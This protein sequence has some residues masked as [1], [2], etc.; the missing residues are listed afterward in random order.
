MY[1]CECF[2]SSGSIKMDRL[3]KDTTSQ[4]MPLAITSEV[5]PEERTEFIELKASLTTFV[6]ELPKMKGQRKDNMM[7]CIQSVI[8]NYIDIAF[9]S[10]VPEAI[11]SQHIHILCHEEMLVPIDLTSWAAQQ[12]DTVYKMPN[13]SQVVGLCPDMPSLPCPPK[14]HP[15][16]FS[17]EILYHTIICCSAFTKCERTTCRQY[18]ES[19]KTGSHLLTEASM[20]V[21]TNAHQYLIARQRDRKLIYV[22]FNSEPKISKWSQKCTFEEG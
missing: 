17:D 3:T 1:Q 21:T 14:K 19:L 10:G 20:T 12:V 6:K 9:Q 16:L 22:A 15:S 18:F 4:M 5:K 7:A 13:V 11:I 2:E 8:N